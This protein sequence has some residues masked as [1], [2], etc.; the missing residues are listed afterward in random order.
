MSTI[1]S[2]ESIFLNIYQS[3]ELGSFS[4]KQK[5]SFT[6]LKRPIA[7]HHEQLKEICDAIFNALGLDSEAISS[8]TYNLENFVNFQKRLELSIWTY[9]ANT[10]QI[11]WQLLS[12]S[13][14]PGVARFMAFWNIADTIDKGMPGGHFW[15]LPTES[16]K[17]NQVT[18]P[19]AQVLD[20]LLDLLG[21]PLDQLRNIDLELIDAESLIRDIYNW[22]NGRIPRLSTI[23]TSF[24]NSLKL[25]FKGCFEPIN[26]GD[27][28]T[29]LNHIQKFIKSKQLSISLLAEQIPMNES[30]ISGILESTIT[31][32]HSFDVLEYLIA[33]R[34][35][36]PSMQMIRRRLQIAKATQDGYV[37]LVK[38]LTPGVSPKDTDLKVNKTLQL[39][40][41]YKYVYNLT[42]ESSKHGK[43]FEEQNE[44]F[45][46]QISEIDQQV[47]FLSISP[48][49]DHYST[50]KLGQFL[51]K[52]FMKMEE[53]S[54]LPDIICTEEKDQL[55]IFR[56]K[57]EELEQFY[58]DADA[59]FS[60]KKALV[61]GNVNCI[62]KEE[63]RFYVLYEVGSLS[64]G[65]VKNKIIQ[66][67]KVIAHSPSQKIQA[68]LEE[69]DYLQSLPLKEQPKSIVVN[70][71]RLIK[72]AE[73]MQEKHYWE[74]PVLLSRAKHLLYTNQFKQASDMY[75]AV[76]QACEYRNYGDLRGLVARDIL[77]T[78]MQ[79]T[80][81]NQNNHEKY[82]REMLANSMLENLPGIPKLSDITDML[83][84]FFWKSLYK[85]YKGIKKLH[86]FSQY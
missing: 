66:R 32:L 38:L 37:R 49:A 40:H 31:D 81:I 62:L 72:Q 75:K 53:E 69:V 27:K 85:P 23:L 36:K 41:L 6:K 52:R 47:L 68:I 65:I 19:V 21:L 54:P 58:K 33:Q 3:L 51:S 45:Y 60:M 79:L 84:N 76:L 24:P 34:Y 61:K 74:A 16:T 48:A 70:C 17:N 73:S 46:A 42:V 13:Y 28:S 8:L 15:Y 35:S 77:A 30:T 56:T 25:E 39:C 78:E 9:D 59:I 83:N 18:M 71:E 50:K 82:L 55:E 43:S 10:R 14:V 1:P 2:A 29:R 67:L 26:S 20:W 80:Q 44:W 4:S 5:N 86:T 64:I 63:K 7:K 11:A 22:K 57:C 12:H